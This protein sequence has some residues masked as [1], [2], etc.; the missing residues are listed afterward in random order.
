MCAIPL[1]VRCAPKGLKGWFTLSL[2]AP[3]FLIRWPLHRG[4][5]IHQCDRGGIRKGCSRP[6]LSQW[7]VVSARAPTTLSPRLSTGP[8]R[9]ASI[10]A[11]NR[12]VA[13]RPRNSPPWHGWIG[14]MTGAYRSRSAISRPL[15]AK[16]GIMP[17]WI[18]QSW[19]RKPKRNSLRQARG[20]SVLRRVTQ[21]R[22]QGLFSQALAWARK[23]RARR[24]C[25]VK[26]T[27]QAGARS[28][29]RH[30]QGEK[31]Q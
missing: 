23:L 26:V 7:S 27:Q 5:L 21:G 18:S 3:V 14:S 13:S 11:A 31:Q 4:G 30:K 16:N 9:P 12:D 17:H 1:H 29:L 8:T 19:Q 20:G 25:R 28:A 2:S 22:R 10:T 15:E 24:H 6:G